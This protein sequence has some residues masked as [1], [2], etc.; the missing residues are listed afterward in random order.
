MSK[1][2]NLWVYSIIKDFEASPKGLDFVWNFTSLW[3]NG[4]QQT[5]CLAKGYNNDKYNEQQYD[6]EVSYRTG[7]EGQYATLSLAGSQNLCQTTKPYLFLY[8]TDTVGRICA[9]VSLTGQVS[10]CYR[11]VLVQWI[12]ISTHVRFS[13]MILLPPSGGCQ[14]SFHFQ[15]VSISFYVA[16]DKIELI[17]APPH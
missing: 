3:I 11:H 1:S 7:P 10:K 6:R 9:L 14:F 16:A 2:Y 4:P 17:W 15:V 8:T 5:A 13:A 12:F